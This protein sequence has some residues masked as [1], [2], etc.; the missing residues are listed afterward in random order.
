[1]TERILVIDD[2]PSLQVTLRDTFEDEGY[3]V[4]VAGTV[5][6][7]LE[8][9]RQSSPDLV[10]CDLR[11]PDGDGLDVVQEAQRWAPMVPVIILTAFASIDSAIAALKAGASEYLT[12]PFDEASLLSMVERHLEVRR[13]RRRVVELEGRPEAPVGRSSGFLR[14]LET[15]RAVA[16]SDRTVLIT[17]ETGTGKDVLARY[18]HA[19]S[20]RSRGPFVAVSCAALPEALLESEL[21]GHVAGA[22][23]GAGSGAQGRFEAASGGTL[24]LDEVAEI[25]PAVQTK[26][27]RV[28]EARS[29]ERLGSTKTISVDVRI[30]AATRKD[31][32]RE[33]AEGRFRDDLYYRLNVVPVQIPP[34]RERREDI[35]LLTRAL[36]DRIAKEEGRKI[37]FAPETIAC[38]ETHPF[39]GNVREL[40]NL[41][42]RM[43]AI[44][45]ADVVRLGHLP[46]EYRRCCPAIDLSE[47]EETIRGTLP[48]MM[49]AFE[50]RA[51][52]AALRHNNG[53]RGRAAGSL[54]ISRKNLWEKLRSHGL[55]DWGKPPGKSGS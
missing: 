16:V 54:G 39:P 1:M 13:L 46:A 3:D 34:L 25:S 18:I 29:F 9:L 5:R 48:E 14:L 45:P 38:M 37:E 36:A 28:L 53:H 33:V 26:L 23:T 21:F 22:F 47:E 11:L 52:E 32:Q 42:R 50:R 6:E 41:I 27:L 10:L 44:C 15:A 40:E 8:A 24:F 2:E 31:L 49:R 4:Q 7:A 17:G 20:S 55:A 35:P 19:C 12:K 51:L 43:V 30:V